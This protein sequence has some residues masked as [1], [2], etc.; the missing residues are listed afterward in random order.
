MEKQSTNDATAMSQSK[1]SVLEADAHVGGSAVLADWNDNGGQNLAGQFGMDNRNIG[2]RRE[3]IRLGEEERK[4]LEEMAPWAKS[5][6]AQIAKEFYDWQFNFGPATGFFENFARENG[7]S[8]AALRTHL[9]ASQSGYFAEVFAGATVNWDVRYFEKRLHI[10]ALHARINLPFKW[11]V[12]AYAESQML[13]GKYLRRDIPDED[14]VR[15]I[16]VAVSKVY[17][18]DLQAIG[19]AFIVVTLQ[20]VLQSM[21]IELD[22]LSITG[23]KSEHIGRIKQF[24]T[25]QFGDFAVDMA[26]MADEHNK[27]DI[28]VTMEPDKF[29]GALKTMAKGVNDMVADHIIVKKKAMACVAEFGRG[30]FDAPLEKF[31]GK[32]AFINENIEK[33]RSNVKQ[34]IADMK[35]MSDEHNRG[36]IDVMIPVTEFEGAFRVMAQGVNDMIAGHIIVKR[37]AMACVAEFGNGNFDAP[38]EK[39]LGKKAFINDTIEQVRDNL[40]SLIV[41]TDLLVKAANDGRLGTRADAT[42]HRGDFRRI[43]EGINKTLET[44]IGPIKVMAENAS[45]LASSAEELTAT[46]QQMASNAEETAVQANVVSAASTEVSKNVSSVAA[47]SEQMQTSIREI[48]KNAA[49]SAHVAKNAVRV[50][51]ST[52]STMKKLGESSTEIGKVVKVIT[53]IAQQT[54][55]LA[56]NATIEAARAGEAGKGFAVVAN[57]VKELAKQTAKATGEIGQQVDA[58]QSDAKGALQA[59]EE[60]GTI[61]RQINELSDSIAA[62]VEEQTATTNEIGRSVKEA[63]HGV[64]NI[65]HNIG[66]VASAAT[67]TTMGA[68]DMQKASQELSKMA[69][70]L[71]SVVSKF[72][73]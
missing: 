31:P 2:A 30:N 47:A 69:A 21:E 9:E 59:I 14:R 22:D 8:I 50:A 1:I 46:S 68:H 42:K 58:I 63:A 15:R 45:T 56:L 54:N 28:D 29:R 12:G 62:A 53:S 67:D 3:F 64:D 26:H 61:I 18:L 40:K 39:F 43:V 34:F 17:N 33:L 73:F 6:A 38:L 7:M 55:L 37:K 44:I 27:G 71:Q 19:D 4:L 60:I 25:S 23:D 5:V 52:N 11:W 24:M 51:E 66:G 13:L 49:Q 32:K 70:R 41:D 16:E 10:G 35:R 48:S 36:D 57:E 72:T 20:N 65:A